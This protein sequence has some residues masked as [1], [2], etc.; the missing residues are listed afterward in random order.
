MTHSTE[1]QEFLARLEVTPDGDDRFVGSCHPAWP[2][3]AFGGQVVAKALQAAAATVDDPGMHPWS[4]HTYFHAPMA[5]GKPA[6]Y[7]V[8]RIKDG[9]TLVNR[10]VRVAQDGKL[11][12]TALVVLGSPGQGPKHRWEVPPVPLPE[13]LTPEERLVHPSLAPI[14]A[15]FEAMGYPADSQVDLRFV[16]ESGDASVSPDSTRRPAWMRLK[17]ELPD[18]A[19][20]A[21]SVLCYLS[22]ITLGTTA[23]EPHGGRGGAPDLQLG[24]L[25]LS[26]WFTRPAPMGQWLLFDFGTPFAGGGRALVQGVIHDADGD[27]VA[28][29]VQNALMRWA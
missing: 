20:T 7:E 8:E 13:E 24:A 10:R 11:R 29:A 3:R 5:S 16:A 4:I 25:E 14:D 23:L 1:S 15:D 17:V 22:D 28:M 9:R 18:D 19:V 2:G 12:A 26:L 6:T 21:A 27:V